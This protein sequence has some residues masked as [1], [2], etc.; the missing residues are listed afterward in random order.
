M[1]HSP[2]GLIRAQ[3]EDAGLVAV[4]IEERKFPG[5]TWHLVFVPPADLPA[6][7]TL[8][9]S[10]EMLL[11]TKEGDD[12][13]TS[14]VFRAREIDE[15]SKPGST[16]QATGLAKPEV[17]NL[18][19]LLEA[20]SRT[21]DAVPSLRYMEDPR[22]NLSTV[23]TTR[24]QVVYGRRGVGKTAILL[25][26]R[27]QADATGHSTVWLNAHLFRGLPAEHA[28][29]T[30]A[31]A[32]FASLARDGGSSN[33]PLFA[34]LSEREVE[35]KNALSSNETSPLAIST[36]LPLL[37]ETLKGVLRPDLLRLYVYL[38]DFYLLP[39]GVQ[40]QFLDYLAGMLRDTDGWIKVAS[41]E[42]LTKTYETSTHVGL[43][44]P[45]DATKID[46][47]VTLEDPGAAQHF[48]EAV[49]D[50]YINTA[51]IKR[52]SAIAK[53]EALGRLVL[54]SGGVPRDYL[55]LFS[56][57][58]TVARANRRDAREIGREDVAQ[59]AGQS[60]R[61]KKRDL[62]Q[63]VN[64][65][66]ADSL[67]RA[68]GVL[69]DAV[70]G[71]G[72]GYFRVNI[73]Q[74]SDEGYELLALLVDLRFAHLINASLSDNHKVGVRYE[75]YIL[76]LSE[77]S[78]V[79]LKRNLNVLDL[80]NGNWVYRLTGTKDSRRQLSGVQLRDRLRSS[81]VINVDDF[82]PEREEA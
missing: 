10:I 34:Q 77:W 27:R 44:I 54:A 19:K 25:E 73:D 5:E 40:P 9:G 52:V 16:P 12:T 65:D 26:A 13:T 32:I 55:N 45:H 11:S 67:I 22:A 24:H 43:E 82:R 33:N 81:P 61:I 30:V 76:D 17:D 60:A 70:K 72:F 4:A 75:A 38:D 14:V 39:M 57:S 66:Y 62:E 42:R 28:F 80:E 48:L 63:D 79:R 58:I 36:L 23:A 15:G 18:I 20:R 37:N 64:R 7:Q 56:S 8:A 47:D 35:L 51:G 53:T 71:A 41:I 46:L 59:A 31:R 50:T 69:S 6:A 29:L 74:K 21:S 68:I 49:L 1:A 3:L 2:Q 78:D